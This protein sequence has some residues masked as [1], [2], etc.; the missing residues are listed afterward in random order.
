LKKVS[1]ISPIVS[2]YNIG[3]SNVNISLKE[4]LVKVEATSASYQD[5]EKAIKNTG[6]VITSG[7]V[8]NFDVV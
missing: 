4:Q 6:K 5:V 1:G 2:S 3:V 7:R 8:V